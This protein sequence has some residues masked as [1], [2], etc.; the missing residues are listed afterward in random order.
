[1]ISYVKSYSNLFNAGRNVSRVA[2]LKKILVMI[3]IHQK[4]KHRSCDDVL[5]DGDQKNDPQKQIK[6]LPK[7]LFN[8]ESVR[9]CNPME[10]KLLA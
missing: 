8:M 6:I 2:Y 9:H 1:M 5:E 7:I 4:T 10:C 3:S